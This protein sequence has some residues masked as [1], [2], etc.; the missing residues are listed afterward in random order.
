MVEGILIAAIALALYLAAGFIIRSRG[1]CAGCG[2][3]P[4]AG[5][6]QREKQ[7]EKMKR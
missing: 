3:C 1:K 4:M 5:S 2:G 7:K 6:C